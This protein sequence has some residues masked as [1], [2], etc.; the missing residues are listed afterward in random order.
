MIEYLTSEFGFNI[1]PD[2]GIGIKPIS[3]L[4]QSV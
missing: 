1:R 4:A 2:S 3:V